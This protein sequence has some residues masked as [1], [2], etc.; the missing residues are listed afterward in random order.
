[1]RNLYKAYYKDYFKDID[2]NYLLLEEEVNRERDKS[3][4]VYYWMS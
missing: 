4:K 2:F 1:M 3:K